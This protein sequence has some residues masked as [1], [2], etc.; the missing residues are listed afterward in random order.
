MSRSAPKPEL[1]SVVH[2]A[3]YPQA[4]TDPPFHF[5]PTPTLGPEPELIPPLHQ[6]P[7]LPSVLMA[8]KYPIKNQTLDTNRRPSD[9]GFFIFI[10]FL[11]FLIIIWLYYYLRYHPGEKDPTF[12]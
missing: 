11:G 5:A 9:T 4:A 3:K 1:P 7:E 10:G 6:K 12:W 8:K 2:A